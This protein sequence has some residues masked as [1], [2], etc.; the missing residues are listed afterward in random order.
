MLEPN[1]LY[2]QAGST[3]CKLLC[4]ETFIPETVEEEEGRHFAFPCTKIEILENDQTLLLVQ[5][6][7]SQVVF[8]P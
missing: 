7:M 6:V 1:A 4:W 5:E 3:D 2:D 8:L